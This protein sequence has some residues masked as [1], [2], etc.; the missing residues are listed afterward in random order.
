[1][2]HAA[3]LVVLAIGVAVSLA[4]QGQAPA[5][6]GSVSVGPAA[7]L[8]PVGGYVNYAKHFGDAAFIWTRNIRLDNLVL[9][10][11]TARGP[12]RTPATR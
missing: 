11:Y 10:R 12:R 2:R 5:P 3:F 6:G 7:N 1:M 9:A 4:A 8:H